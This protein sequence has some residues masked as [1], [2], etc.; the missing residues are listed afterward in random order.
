MFTFTL[1]RDPPYASDH[2]CHFMSVCHARGTWK[3]TSD[4]VQVLCYLC[5]QGEGVQWYKAFHEGPNQGG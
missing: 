4:Y 2:S 3:H 1:L 5:A